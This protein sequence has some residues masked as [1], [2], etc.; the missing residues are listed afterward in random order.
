M[1]LSRL[2]VLATACLSV[3]ANFTYD[4]THFFL[5]GKPF[6]IIGGQMDPQ[7]IPRAYWR[8]RLQMARSMGLNTIF[9]YVFWNKLEPEP[10]RWDFGDTNDIAAFFRLAQEEGLKVVLR[11]GP[12]VCAERDWGG[13]PAWLSKIHGLRVR[14][15]NIPFLEAS[16]SYISELGRELRSLQTTRGGPILMVQLENEYGSF[17]KDKAYLQAIADM[18]KA[19]FDLVLYTNDG[20]GRDYLEGGTLPGVLAETDG[21]PR[22]GF[23]A[24][25]QFVKDK[26]MLGPQLAGEY[27]TTW[28][29]HWSSNMSHQLT[30]NVA[31]ITDDLD[32][33]LKQGHSFNLFMFH[34]GTNW[35]FENGAIWQD[36]RT[37]AVTT[38]YDYGAP[39]DET[40]RTGSLYHEIRRIISYHVPR[41]SIPDVPEVPMLNSFGEIPLRAALTL[42]DTLADSSH[43]S[44]NPMTMESLGQATGF[45][46]YAHNVVDSVSGELIVGD[47]PRDRVIVYQNGEKI[48]VVDATYSKPAKLQLALKPGDL[49]QLLVENLGRVDVGQKMDDQRKGIVGEVKVGADHVLKTW[50]AY[51]LPLDKLPGELSNGFNLAVPYRSPPVFYRTIFTLTKDTPPGIGSDSLLSLR[52]STKGQVWVNGHNLGRYWTVGPQQSLYLPGCFLNAPGRPNELVVLEL[53]PQRNRPMAVV[54]L[55]SRLW[56]NTPDPDLER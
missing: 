40:G 49:L 52:R 23:A 54:G 39:L 29:D 51:P 12:Y 36:G 18:L 56:F 53:E 11:P 8:H 20:G 28:F 43:K 13:L 55:R 37:W 50:T 14:R 9:S 42:F 27:Y 48:G 30:Y 41:G 24:R 46:L 5:D 4:E 34:G 16:K 21:D 17:G 44:A 38:S 31:R 7:R 2:L 45:V 22:V 1:L 15:N 35:G 19:S 32:W 47:G 25:D 10:G 3:G 26:S 6:Q 33:I